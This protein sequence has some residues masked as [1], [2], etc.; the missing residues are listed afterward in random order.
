V[1]GRTGIRQVD[2]GNIVHAA[3]ATGLVVLTTLKPISVVFT[4]PQQAL[5]AVAAAIAAGP[6]E[7]LAL[8]Q[9]ADQATATRP[10]LDR[11]TL[12]VLDNQVDPTPAPSS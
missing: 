1:D 9:S 6:P 10:L 2:A 4:L 3:D 7:V 8:P 12:T 11:G 5:P